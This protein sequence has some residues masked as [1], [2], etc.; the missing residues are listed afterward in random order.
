MT[1]KMANTEYDRDDKGDKMVARMMMP[2]RAL[3]KQKWCH[4][5]YLKVG[6]HCD[7]DSGTHTQ[8]KGKE[9]DINYIM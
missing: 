9:S 6:Y 5:L 4:L 8:F 2:G 3:L 1:M 7:C